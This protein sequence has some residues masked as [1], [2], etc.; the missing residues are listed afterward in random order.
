MENFNEL[1]LPETLLGALE[2]MEFSTPTPI[3]AASIP[4]AL[5]GRDILGSAQTGTGKTAAFAIPMIAH[6][7]KNPHSTAL[8]LSPTREL[9]TQIM[10]TVRKLIDNGDG[11][12]SMRTALLIGGEDIGKQL[13]QLKNNPRLV[14]G[15]PGRINDHLKRR[16]L[17]LGSADF[18][19]MDETDRMLDM[20][21]GEQIETIVALM[22][23]SRQTL[24]F[25][26]T[27][28]PYALK[29]ASK[30]LNNPERIAV[31]SVTNPIDRIDQK[32]MNI[33]THEKFEVLSLECREREGSIIVF[34]KT[35]HGADKLAERLSE[36]VPGV[37]VL[38][39][40]MKQGRRD[41]VV[42]MFKDQRTRVLIATDVAARGLDVPHIAHVINYDAPQCPEDYVHRIGRTARAGAEGHA[43]CLITPE[44]RRKWS[45][46]QRFIGGDQ[47]HIQQSGRAPQ[48]RGE[49]RRDNYRDGANRDGG[50]K[51]GG[52]KPWQKKKSF[53]D[54]GERSFGDRQ[55]GDRQ[56]GD[57]Q[58]ADRQPRSDWTPHNG[59]DRDNAQQGGERQFRQDRPF[60]GDKPF[61][62]S[63]DN[64][65]RSG[66]FNRDRNDRPARFDD[67][68]DRFERTDRP[69]RDRDEGQSFDGQR[70]GAVR[71]DRDGQR[72]EGQRDGQRHEGQRNDGQRYEQRDSKPFGKKPY[73]E[74][75][76]GDK[77]F[78]KKPG[79]FA[80]K[81]YGDKPR[82]D[83]DKPRQDGD[84]PFGDKPDWKKRD[85]SKP[86]AK[87]PYG[88]KPQGE[89]SSF[90]EKKF[91]DRKFG[92]KP[93]FG[94]KP[95]AKKDGGKPHFGKKP[96]GF[97]KKSHYAA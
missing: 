21:F 74:K 14:I 26:A 59:G 36:E 61:K 8:I 57:R 7:L 28:P 49:F 20:G 96:G 3:Q 64:K 90:G 31:G 41:R 92:D 2:R 76:Y 86:F 11:T 63:W 51:R 72:H 58:F 69:Q 6:L 91:G 46:V 71:G 85:G 83:S 9:A 89:K 67:R 23:E 29:L 13:R 81:P 54:R 65:P 4:V 27:L 77:P 95:F 68:G 37:D 56:Y 40:G 35:K 75:S 80:K 62:K 33:G 73:G 42:R 47:D 79:G 24:L 12:F 30:Y 50:F 82:Y 87:K 93:A 34:V 53:G 52:D 18:L 17:Q 84:R 19:V 78:G 45:A 97:A 25:S 94:K 70:F 10:Q 39:G 22:P 48:K 44:D 88:D 32:M 60:N 43:L 5:E 16:S 15:T 38:H 66:G 55:F 1:N